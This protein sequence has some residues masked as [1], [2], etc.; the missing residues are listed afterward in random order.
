MTD[1]S[2]WKEI[3]TSEQY[4]VCINCGTE[5]PFQ[6]KYWNC[7]E[8]G[9]YHCVCCNCKLFDSK[10]KFD[11]GTGWPSFSKAYENSIKYTEDLKYGMKRIEVS[12]LECGSHLGHVFDDGPKPSGK[13][14]CINSASMNLI[15]QIEE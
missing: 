14:Y 8:K 15:P 6:N 1:K 3:L 4:E 9:V 10:E 11:S 12:C 5:P 7:K 2:E 13:R